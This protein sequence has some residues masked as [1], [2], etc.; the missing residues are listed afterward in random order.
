[1]IQE[2]IEPVLYFRNPNISPVEEYTIRKQECI[3]YAEG[4][5]LTVIDA[6][7][8]HSAWLERVRGLESEPERGS[9]CLECFTMRLTDA[10]RYASEHGFKV[11]TSTLDSSRWKSHDQIVAAGR[12]AE[13]AYPG[14]RFWDHNWRKGGLQQRRSEIIAEQQFYNQKYCGCEF[15][16]RSMKVDKTECRKRIRRL[17]AAMTDNQKTTESQSVWSRVESM[18]QFISARSIMIY[19]SMDDEVQTPAFISRWYGRKEILLPSIE[20][21]RLVARSYTGPESLK[22]G[23]SFGIP[24]PVGPAVTDLSSLDMVIVPGRAFDACGGRMGRGKG[25]YDSF[26][27]GVSAFKV[28]VCFNCQLIPC[29]PTD[30]HD[31]R[32]DITVASDPNFTSLP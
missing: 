18:P 7:Y 1:M 10:A 22:T 26:L 5:G 12:A 25:F 28:G 8:D 2:G 11:F 9:R 13:K 4:L 14:V 20:G 6:D 3:R 17:V 27:S 15:S 16:M 32:M 31:I 30:D 19:W 21:D 29:V 23:P 24:E